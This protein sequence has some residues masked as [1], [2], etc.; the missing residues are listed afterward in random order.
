MIRLYFAG[1]DLNYAVLPHIIAFM[2]VAKTK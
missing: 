2:L 1:D